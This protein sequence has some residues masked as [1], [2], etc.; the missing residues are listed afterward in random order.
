[1]ARDEALRVAQAMAE[2]VRLAILERLLDGPATV[3]DLVV[4]TGATQPNVSNHLA[5]LREADL[6]RAERKGRTAVYRLRGREVSSLMRS[7]A[8]AAGGGVRRPSP[9]HPLAVARSCYDHPAGRLGVE[10]LDGLVRRHALEPPR[11]A[12]R[13]I[14][15][16][17][18]ADEVFRSIGVDPG[19]A[20]GQRRRLA[21]GC[22][23]WTERRPHLGGAL[24]SAVLARLEEAGWVERIP[25]TR[26]LT[27]THGG[28]R[29]LRRA[30]GVSLA[31]GPEG[32]SLS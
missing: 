30:L 27:V 15:L 16:G 23:D 7:L 25:G 28:R 6:V 26:A 29:K 10:I 21:F 12:G 5:V 20:G 9:S 8:H 19:V 17:R 2:P 11:G 32:R 24:G 22:L 31:Q 4:R 13:D 3:A 18:H 1:M 14:R